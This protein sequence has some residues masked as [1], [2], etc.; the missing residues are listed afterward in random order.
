MRKIC[1]V[2]CSGSG[3]TTFARRLAETLDVPHLELDSIYHQAGWEALATEEF[4]AKVGGFADQNGWVIDGNYFTQIGDITWDAADS[5]VWM[6]PSRLVATERVV[7][8]TLGRVLLH[9]ELWNGNRENWRDVLSRDPE[10]SIIAWAWKMHGK[11][12][13]RYETAMTDPRWRHLRF[14]RLQSQGEVRRF[15]EEASS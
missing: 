1:V 5:V 10:K 13:E 8:R 4:R 11:Y 12:K 15:L 9:K 2:G 14:T 7:R 3:K 6:D